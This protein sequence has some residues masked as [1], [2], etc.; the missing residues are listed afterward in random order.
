LS[1]EE[2]VPNEIEDR[3]LREFGRVKLPTILRSA[4]NRATFPELRPTVS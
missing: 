1:I 4:L 3:S 2:I